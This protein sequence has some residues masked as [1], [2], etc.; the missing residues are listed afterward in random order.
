LEQGSDST[1]NNKVASYYKSSLGLFAENT[2]DTAWHYYALSFDGNTLVMYVDGEKTASMAS[3]AGEIQ[4]NPL[5]I[6][7]QSKSIS[8]YWK[9]AID[10]ISIYNRA[11]DS[12][13]ILYHYEMKD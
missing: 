7:A 12:T 1:A 9:G 4:D 8:R 11:L 6:G 5:R 10:D 2:L 3:S 13:E